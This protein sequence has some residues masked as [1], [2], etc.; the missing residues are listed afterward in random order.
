MPHLEHCLAHEGIMT[1]LA[2]T[3][4]ER[5]LKKRREML[6]FHLPFLTGFLF[7][8]I[9]FKIRKNNSFEVTQLS[10]D[11]FSLQILHITPNNPFFFVIPN[12][13]Q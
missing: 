4:L 1:G 3:I 12:C 9:N 8:F 7:C 6:A 2:V 11:E 5:E 13:K 10:L